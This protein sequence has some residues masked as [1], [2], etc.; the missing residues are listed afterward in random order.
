MSDVEGSKALIKVDSAETVAD[1]VALVAWLQA[2]RGLHGRVRV[3]HAAPAE[4]ELGAALDLLTV[5][6]GSGGIATILAGSLSAWLQ[7]RRSQTTIRITITRADRTLELE[8]GD[9]AEAEDLI[10]RFLSDD[11]NEA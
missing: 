7:N 10:R 6:L 3:A 9:A 11:T 4:N 8:T 2:E 5:S 1:Q